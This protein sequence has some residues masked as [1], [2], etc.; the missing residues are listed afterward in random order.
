MKPKS[1]TLLEAYQYL[2]KYQLSDSLYLIG[3][4]NAALKYGSAHLQTDDIPKE[5]AIW[6]GRATQPGMRFNIYT[7]ATRLARLLLLSGTNDYRGKPLSL[8]DNSLPF[9]LDVAGASYD[10]ELEDQLKNASSNLT[11]NILG[12]IGQTQFPLQGNRLSLIGRALLLFEMLPQS[13]NGNYSINQKL[14]EYFDINV[15][16]F[17][18]TGLALWIKCDGSIDYNLEIES[19]LDKY[20]NDAT[21]QA[22]L[23][24]SSGTSEDYKR[25][26]R[27]ENWKVPSKLFDTYFL[28]PLL[29]MPAIK[30]EASST[31]KKGAYVVPQSKYL[32]DR[33]STGIFYLL[34]DKEQQLGQAAGKMK[35]NAFR[36][37]FGDVYRAY[38][39]TQLMQA[40][41]DTLLI[42]LD[43]DFE[44]KSGEKLP[45][46]ALI[47]GN[48]CIVIE[49]KTSLLTLKS[50]AFFDEATMEQE[51]KA[52]SFKKAV[53]QLYEFRN[54]ILLN[55]TGDPRFK[56][57]SEVISI[58][59]GYEDIFVLNSYLLPMLDEQYGKLT[60]NLQL[61]SISD[62]DSL[63][64]ILGEG[65]SITE[66]MKL[67]INNSETRSWM[68]E[69]Y[70]KDHIH[71]EN[72]VLKEG[73]NSLLERL[74]VL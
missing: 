15:M 48:T 59:A 63:G 36:V 11:N 26:I 12:R 58:L 72:K 43:E 55:Q 73:F 61:A 29:Q 40:N 20:A 14:T 34:A 1:Y 49:V 66:L 23:K 13:V 35:Q 50:R 71:T 9:A 54:R 65:Q 64:S 52:G 8:L 5:V 2:K 27:G 74:R 70:L 57:V 69:Q 31:L 10:P 18:T 62:I 28:E 38:V 17:I 45:D 46:F 42:D 68:L 6:L 4:V 56:F 25:I 60:K 21:Q 44:N 30:V 32:L 7:S 47:Q 41:G 51:I 16:E 53:I 3:A 19:P 24:L 39:K 67:K 22:F 37:Y 33:A